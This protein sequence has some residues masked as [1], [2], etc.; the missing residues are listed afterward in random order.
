MN[1]ARLASMSAG[2]ILLL[3][4]VVFFSWTVVA[5]SSTSAVPEPCYG[6]YSTGVLTG[7]GASC[8]AAHTNL[9]S[10]ANSQAIARCS[11][12][13]ICNQNQ[14]YTDPCHACTGGYEAKGYMT[15]GCEGLDP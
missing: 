11:P 5:P 12:F 3:A 6:S 7:T 1:K 14:V 13:W 8:T 15:Y 2:G 10:Q 4:A 9:W